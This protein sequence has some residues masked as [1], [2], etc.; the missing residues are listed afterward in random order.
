MVV[1]YGSVIKVQ[2]KKC[3]FCKQEVRFLGHAATDPEKM[4]KVPILLNK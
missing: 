2:L 3:S 4:V 1:S